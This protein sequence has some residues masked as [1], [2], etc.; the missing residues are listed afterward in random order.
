MIALNL[1]AKGAEQEIVKKYLEENASEVLADKINNGVRIEKDGKTLIS[2]KT[3]DGFMKYANEE[4]RKQAEK[5]AT[6]A[7]IIGDV[8]FGWAV[9]YFEEDSIKGTLYNEDGTEYKAPRPAK[10]ATKTTVKTTPPIKKEEPK[11]DQLSFFDFSEET[12]EEPTETIEEN[13]DGQVQKTEE[14]PEKPKVSPLLERYTSFKNKYPDYIIAFR[15]GDFYEIFG[16]DAKQVASVLDLTLV[17][18]D[19][20]LE[21]KLPMVGYPYH[22]EDVYRGKLQKTFDVVV[23]ENDTDV[24][25]YNKIEADKPSYTVDIQTGELLEEPAVN[26][27][28]L[29]QTI[30]KLFDGDLEVHTK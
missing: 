2:R 21:E 15:I 26:G 27:D 22:K 23:V 10:T 17:G 25:F 14:A 29:L 30:M 24:K 13:E 16:D 19:V 5:G 11:V 20:G 6:S 18:R 28:D 7:C 8:V 3:L 12:I 4:A 1:T 9:H